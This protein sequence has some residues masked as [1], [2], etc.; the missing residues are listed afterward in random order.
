MD[1]TRSY[2]IRV[3]IDGEQLPVI[4]IMPAK[5]DVIKVVFYPK[6]CRSEEVRRKLIEIISIQSTTDRNLVLSSEDKCD[7]EIGPLI[8]KVSGYFDLFEPFEIPTSEIK[9]LF[10]EWYEFLLAYET[11]C[12]PGII[13]PNKKKDWVIVPKSKVISN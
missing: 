2:S 8:T 10:E 3:N 7:M 13:P 1:W 9:K 5:L 12:I 6:L 11:G 4:H